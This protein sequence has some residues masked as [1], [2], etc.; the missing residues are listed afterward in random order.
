MIRESLELKTQ[1]DKQ[2]YVSLD[3]DW[4]RVK[5]IR[6]REREREKERDREIEKERGRERER[7]RETA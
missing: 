4:E 5:E 6:K 2:E 1:S 7:E 3:T